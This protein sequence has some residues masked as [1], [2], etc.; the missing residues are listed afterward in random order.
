MDRMDEMDGID[1]MD[2]M[3]GMVAERTRLVSRASA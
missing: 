1:G 2:G 3:D